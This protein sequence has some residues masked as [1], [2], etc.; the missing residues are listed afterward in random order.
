ML[1]VPEEDEE[2]GDDLDAG[3]SLLS[4]QTYDDV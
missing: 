4:T 1:P 2:M 3:E